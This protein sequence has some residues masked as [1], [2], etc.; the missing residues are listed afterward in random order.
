M[1]NIEIKINAIKEITK[2][3]INAIKE[4]EDEDEINE[5][6]KN[7]EE[8]IK[9]E[10]KTKD[11]DK[12]NDECDE[13]KNEGNED[14]DEDE[15]DVILK[16]I[17]EKKLTVFDFSNRLIRIHSFFNTEIRFIQ[18]SKLKIQ[19]RENKLDDFIKEVNIK[20]KKA[21]IKERINNFYEIATEEERDRLDYTVRILK[22]D[23]L[24][25]LQ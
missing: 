17:K 1:K 2:I 24:S 22:T 6:V 16:E 23:N 18:N 25:S 20:I 10:V 7:T 3:A 13:D 19:K 8:K 11:R 9:E 4:L 5:V 12:D 14:R 15:L 21:K